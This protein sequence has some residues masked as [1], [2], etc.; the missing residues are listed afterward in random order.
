M[1]RFLFFICSAF[2]V[3]SSPVF[4]QTD[5]ESVESIEAVQ[6]Q[7]VLISENQGEPQNTEP[8]SAKK[9]QKSSKKAPKKAKEKPAK[10]S[11]PAESKSERKADK[12]IPE[13]S[14]EVVFNVNCP[15]E[16]ATLVRQI[17]FLATIDNYD[18][19]LKAVLSNKTPNDNEIVLGD[20]F[21]M[22]SQIKYALEISHGVEYELSFKMSSK[23]TESTA[24]EESLQT[25]SEDEIPAADTEPEEYATLDHT[26][27]FS[28]IADILIDSDA[29]FVNVFYSVKEVV[30]ESPALSDNQ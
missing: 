13:K 19:S 27:S 4:A 12:K 2:F 11:K 23:K 5:D 15:L 1:K 30:D 18:G 20:Y 17:E 8:A 14:V 25:Q 7:E 16:T 21:F 10:K 9:S 29:A 26:K 22:C 28:D 6:Q 24:L 3:L